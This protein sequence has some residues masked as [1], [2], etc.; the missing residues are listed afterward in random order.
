MAGPSRRHEQPS[1]DLRGVALAPLGYQ[2]GR[3]PTS[4]IPAVIPDMPIVAR[5]SGTTAPSAFTAS[6]RIN[7][8]DSTAT[9]TSARQAVVTGGGI[10]HPRRIRTLLWP[11][12][13]A[14]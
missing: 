5:S 7:A 13:W 11:G 10:V 14:S 1:Q 8:R 3:G 2:L 6:R 12:L 4:R 9:T